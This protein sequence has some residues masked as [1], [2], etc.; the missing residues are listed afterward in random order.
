[1]LASHQHIVRGAAAIALAA[2]AYAW[3]HAVAAGGQASPDRVGA[4]VAIVHDAPVPVPTPPPQEPAD[5]R[6]DQD[7]NVAPSEPFGAVLANANSPDLR[8]KWLRVSEEMASNRRLVEA[9]RTRPDHCGSPGVGRLAAIVAAAMERDGRARIGEINRAVNLAVRPVRDLAQYG[10]ADYWAAPVDTLGAGAGDCEDYAI[11]K[12]LALQ[13]AGIADDD[14]R[15]VI[16][17]ERRSKEDHAVATVRRDG[18]WF[19]L[20]SRRMAIVEDVDASDYSPLVTISTAR[21]MQVIDSAAAHPG[22][23]PASLRR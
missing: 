6:P 8:L 18:R 3:V 5:A 1:M 12:L 19:L 16:V 22:V 14:L 15:L 4:R 23:A 10:V 13:L 17:R 11:A 2:S 9:C 20:D 21:I 7:A